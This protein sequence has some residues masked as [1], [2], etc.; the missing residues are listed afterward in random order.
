MPSTA[1]RAGRLPTRDHTDRN[2]PDSSH[3]R[4]GV[5][6]RATATHVRLFTVMAR[7]K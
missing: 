4:H 1:P 6:P 3:H 5:L 7:S 2:A